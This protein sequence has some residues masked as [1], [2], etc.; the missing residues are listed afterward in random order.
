MNRNIT[1]EQEVL[2]FM[3]RTDNYSESSTESD[4]HTQITKYLS[5]LTVNVN[6]LNFPPLKDIIWQLELKSK[7]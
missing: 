1:N 7:T 4:A 3:R 6:G 5:I 2:N